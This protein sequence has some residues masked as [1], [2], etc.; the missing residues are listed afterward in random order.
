MKKI[1]IPTYK[2]TTCYS[3]RPTACAECKEHVNLTFVNCPDT[4]VG[5]DEMSEHLIGLIKYY[6][7]YKDGKDEKTMKETMHQCELLGKY[8]EELK[9]NKADG[10]FIFEDYSVSLNP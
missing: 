4:R 5:K 10:L 8:M 1:F 3:F 2:C 7:N 9:K 6:Y